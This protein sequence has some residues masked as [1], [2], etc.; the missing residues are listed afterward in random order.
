MMKRER[1]RERDLDREAKNATTMTG[2]GW[3]NAYQQ[4]A[5]KNTDVDGT[6][7]HFETDRKRTHERR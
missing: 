3:S 1:E 4:K 2:W 7:I 6:T 5:V